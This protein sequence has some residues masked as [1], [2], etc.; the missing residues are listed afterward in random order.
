MSS[1]MG[2]FLAQALA[3]SQTGQAR[4]P[5]YQSGVRMEET[6]RDIQDLEQ[7]LGKLTLICLAL[8]SLVQEKTNLKEEDLL[9]RVQQIDLLDGTQDG[10]ITPQIAQ[11]SQ[12]GRVMNPR[13]QKCLYCGHPRLVISAFDA[14]T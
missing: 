2:A 6:R 13:H 8:W 10:R 14:I 11:C 9:Q 1:I 4:V 12:C 3:E 7:R 5:S